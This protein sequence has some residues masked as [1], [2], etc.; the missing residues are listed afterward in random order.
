MLCVDHFFMRCLII[1]DTTT[2]SKYWYYKYVQLLGGAKTY[3]RPPPPPL[4]ILGGGALPRPPASYASGFNIVGIVQI[5]IFSYANPF[6]AAHVH[7]CW[8]G[9]I[10]CLPSHI[11]VC[12]FPGYHR[13]KAACYF[14][15]CEFS[16]SVFNIDI[17][18]VELYCKCNSQCDH[19][20]SC[21]TTR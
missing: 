11:I 16:G 21:F 19:C 17:C 7:D 12:C 9:A 8:Y 14:V 4:F 5:Q 6:S 2:H 13:S 18:R 1:S 3:F 10:T 15:H 20:G